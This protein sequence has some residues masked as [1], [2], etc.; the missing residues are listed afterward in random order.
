MVPLNT[1][2]NFLH[3]FCLVRTGFHSTPTFNVQTL[4][5]ALWFHDI[6]VGKG[7]WQNHKLETMCL[8]VATDT[9]ITAILSTNTQDFPVPTQFYGSTKFILH[10]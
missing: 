3:N 8:N 9:T 7:H 1:N 4:A 6:K 2:I 10:E 5:K